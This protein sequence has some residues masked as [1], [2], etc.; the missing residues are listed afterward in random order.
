MILLS[1]CLFLPGLN[2]DNCD[3]P[4]NG[5]TCQDLNSGVDKLTNLIARPRSSQVRFICEAFTDSERL[6]IRL[7]TVAFAL[8]TDSIPI[9]SAHSHFSA[10]EIATV[11][12]DSSPQNLATFSFC[13][14][15]SALK[16]G[17]TFSWSLSAN[18][19]HL[20][21]N[22]TLARLYEELGPAAL[23][24]LM[25]YTLNLTDAIERKEYNVIVGRVQC[26]EYAGREFKDK[27]RYALLMEA[28]ASATVVQQ[29]PS[30]AGFLANLIRGEAPV[31][32]DMVG[33]ACWKARSYIA[34]GTNP[35][36]PGTGRS[37]LDLARSNTA[38]PDAA[39]ARKVIANLI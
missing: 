5:Y 14:N 38:C 18:P 10:P 22:P 24:I 6:F 30:L 28:A 19:A 8:A 13:E 17:A 39:Y 31:L 33:G 7:F 29:L 16:S 2:R 11:V 37:A 15:V 36:Y 27:S 25:H 20:L 12:P 26:A 21:F 1:L 35:L 32:Y 9:L 3:A 4:Q 23:H 34:G